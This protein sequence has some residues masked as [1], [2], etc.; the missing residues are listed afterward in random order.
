MVRIQLKNA[1]GADVFDAA[2]LAA[3]PPGYVQVAPVYNGEELTVVPS[4]LPGGPNFHT[5]ADYPGP[6]WS[7][8]RQGNGDAS[9]TFP[10]V[11]GTWD[12]LYGAN[13]DQF[14]L[15][16]DDDKNMANAALQAVVNF[17]VSQR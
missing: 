14:T 1:D 2:A 12:P 15:Y 4:G 9:V 7:E 8:R 16:V 6:T 3:N 11:G 5:L 17:Q 10:A 13:T